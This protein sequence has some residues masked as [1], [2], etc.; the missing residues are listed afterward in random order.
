MCVRVQRTYVHGVR[1]GNKIIH[2]LK[3]NKT[4]GWV[5]NEKLKR[6]NAS[7]VV[8]KKQLVRKPQTAAGFSLK[9]QRKRG[10]NNVIKWKRKLKKTEYIFNERKNTSV[11][12]GL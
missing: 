10:K 8:E 7:C 1:L 9:Y 11:Y 12:G 5:D 2:H 3:Q 6:Y 4:Y